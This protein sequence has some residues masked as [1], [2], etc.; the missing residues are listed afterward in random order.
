MMRRHPELLALRDRAN[1]ALGFAYLQAEQ[2]DARASGARARA[3]ERP[4][5]EQGAARHRLG[6][7]G[8]RG[9]PGRAHP[10]DGAAQPQ[11]ARCRRAGVL[12]GRAVRLQQ[13]QRQRAV[14]AST[15]RAPSKSFDAE[16]VRLD[17]RHQPHRDRATCSSTCSP[18]S[19][20]Q[21][22]HVRL[23]LAAE[24]PARGAR[25]ALPVHDAR[26]PRLPGRPE[27]LPRPGVH[28]RHARCAGRD[29]HGGVRGHDRH[30]RARLRRAPAARR[31]A[32][33]L[34]RRRTAAAARRGARERAAHHRGAARRRR[35][36]HRRGARAV[37]AHP[38]RRG[39]AR[40]RARTPRTTPSCASGW[41]W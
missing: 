29:E 19:A 22:A 11:P 31:R 21:N 4:V 13:A 24:E 40:R 34:G 30:A 8:A 32:A 35:A 10:L 18:R 36:R 20:A 12:S 14:G 39:G 2:P 37:G 9:L 26:R 41:R 27:E 16:N 33:G 25:V 5:F 1:L 28:E 6:G 23:V 15:T 3:P 17:R 7:R 38:A